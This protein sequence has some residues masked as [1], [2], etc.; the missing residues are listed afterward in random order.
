MAGFVNLGWSTAKKE[1]RGGTDK[2]YYGK[3]DKN[4]FFH[5][6][7]WG[8]K[9]SIKRTKMWVRMERWTNGYYKTE[10]V[11]IGYVTAHKSFQ[12]NFSLKGM[13]SGTYRFKVNFADGDYNYTGSVQVKR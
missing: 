2:N 3:K 11:V 13:P 6:T 5:V 7:Y 9:R 12:K 4:I 10:K 8:N 1:F